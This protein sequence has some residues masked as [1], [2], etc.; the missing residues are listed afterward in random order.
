MTFL[1]LMKSIFTYLLFFFL[2]LFALVHG[3]GSVKGYITDFSILEDA[4][5]IEMNDEFGI[6]GP[7][8]LCL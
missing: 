6:T 3:I 7:D 1:P 5:G 4:A 8:E 2:F